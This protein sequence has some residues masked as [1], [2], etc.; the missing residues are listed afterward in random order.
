MNLLHKG[1]F[2]GML[3][4]LKM[5]NYGTTIIRPLAYVKEEQVITFAQQNNFLRVSCKCPVGQHSMRGKVGELLKEMEELFPH[6][7]QNLARA[8][9]EYGS[10]KAKIP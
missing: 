4:T 1:E 10:D 7:R 6:S 8:S 2:A 3:P 5:V 9:L